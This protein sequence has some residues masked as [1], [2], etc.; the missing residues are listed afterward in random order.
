L[1]I[2]YDHQIFSMQ[3]YG[4]ISRYFAAL[5]ARISSRIVVAYSENE[6]IKHI[7]LLMNTALG[8]WLFSGHFKRM[9]RWNR[10][11][12][13]WHIKLGGYDVFHPTYYDPSFLVH[14]KKPFV[15][16]VHDMAHETYPDIFWDSAE[17]MDG[18]RQ[19]IAGAS[20]VIAISEY[21][22]KDII[23]F[24]PQAASK[25][26][27]VYHGYTFDEQLASTPV[28]APD[29]YL[30]FVGERDNYKNFLPMVTAIAPLLQ[31][32][33]NLHLVCTGAHPFSA[34]EQQVL[35]DLKISPQCIQLNATDAE[36]KYLY[37]H[38]LLFV[39]PSLHEGFGF[40]VL[41]AFANNCPVACSNNTAL[42]EVA[43]DAAI[44]FDPLNAD[45]MRASISQLLNNTG[46]QEKLKIKG[47]QRL[48]LFTIDRCVENTVKVYQ[49]VL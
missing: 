49:S 13:Q 18:K 34:E 29:R 16:T 2:L 23:R 43:G 46:L 1:K 38:A 40:P 11:F 44:Y 5:H 37:S 48:A 12:V 33:N 6:Y 14:N 7:T 3:R 45:D 47:R 8:R 17:V 42:P 25:V 4:G 39:F 41:E 36:M 21:T 19:L 10:R 31:E 28:A 20:A 30:L 9:Y 26:S 27:V 22:C 15:L 32:D 35:S 24:F